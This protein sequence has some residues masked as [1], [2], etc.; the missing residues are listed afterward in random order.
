MSNK[1]KKHFFFPDR[2]WILR[3]YER[4]L[5]VVRLLLNTVVPILHKKGHVQY[6]DS[7]FLLFIVY[8]FPGV[9]FRALSAAATVRQYGVRLFSV[10]WNIFNYVFR[11]VLDAMYSRFCSCWLYLFVNL[12]FDGALCR[13]FITFSAM[14]LCCVMR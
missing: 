4:I 9:G 10:G 1:D 13:C 8:Y 5:K 6:R 2:V 11:F 7:V 14:S 12:I 3:I